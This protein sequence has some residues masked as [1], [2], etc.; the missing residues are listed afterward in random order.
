[1]SA[2][3]LDLDALRAASEPWQLT[4]GGRTYTAR[5]VSIEQMIAHEAECLGAS[6]AVVMRSRR[7]LL[8]IAFPW[9]PS[10]WW[11]GDPVALICESP[12]AIHRELIQSFYQSLQSLR[13]PN[14]TRATPPSSNS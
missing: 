5:P 8:R 1:M 13:S 11:R 6:G 4:V 3:A 9:R 10:F 14:G 2:H 7:K 12:P